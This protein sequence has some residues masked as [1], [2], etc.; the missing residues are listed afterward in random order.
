[1]GLSRSTA[2][3][4]ALLLLAHPAAGEEEALARVAGLR[5]QAWP[6]SRIIAFADELLER[7]GRLVDALATFYRRTLQSRPHLIGELRA[8][9]RG[10]EVE[11]A[12]LVA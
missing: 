9:G 5:P 8:S 1:M 12:G 10:A 2:A 7:R 3:T 6:N 4:V 11:M